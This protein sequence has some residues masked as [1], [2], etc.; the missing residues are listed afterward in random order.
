MKIKFD[1]K[2]KKSGSSIRDKFKP[3]DK[4]V[5]DKIYEGREK[6]SSGGGGRSIF[7]TEILDELGITEFKPNLRKEGTYFGEVLPCSHEPDDPYFLE[8]PEHG[9]VGPN[10]DKFVCMQRFVEG[11]QC[12]RCKKQRELYGIHKTTTDE[13][14]AL[15][16]TDRVLYLWWD[17]SEE[18]ENGEEPVYEISV[19]DAPKKGV[20]SEIQGKVRDKLKK[21]I[22]DISDVTENGEGRTVYFQIEIAEVVDKKTGQKRKFPNYT[23]FDLVERETP[24][25]DEILEKLDEII[26]ELKKRM[27]KKMKN[28][29]E[30]LLHFPSYEEVED[31]MKSE[32]YDEDEN[33]KPKSRLQEMKEKREKKEKQLKKLDEDEDDE[34]GVDL[35][36]VEEQL[37]EMSKQEIFKWLKKNG[38]KELIDEDSSK[39]ELIK[40]IL[41]HL[42]EMDEDDIPF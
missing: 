26:S 39:K 16:P 9:G 19:W 27:T 23:S 10:K 32:I 14:K 6:R 22:L 42:V 34:N 25:P 29:L 41:E 40:S 7:N 30:V 33:E 17:R 1:K 12:Y 20:H 36:E 24:I 35:D 31:A 13:I 15:F 4:S 2:K 3:K 8:V 21:Q 28:P 5:L 11:G 37:S 18:L 38:M